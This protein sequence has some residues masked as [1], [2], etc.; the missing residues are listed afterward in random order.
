MKMHKNL[1]PDRVFKHYVIT[2]VIRGEFEGYRKS[3]RSLGAARF[4]AKHLKDAD[5]ATQYIIVGYDDPS[6][7]YPVDYWVL[8]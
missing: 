6:D 5:L 8:S 3:V 4:I 2:A 1:T 7:V